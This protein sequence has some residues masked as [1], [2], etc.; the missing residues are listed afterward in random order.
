MKKLLA[1]LVGILPALS[2]SIVAMADQ[3]P[4]PQ[5]L[6]TEVENLGWQQ[7]PGIYKL[8]RSKSTLTLPEGMEIV[9]DADARRFLF[10]ANGAEFPETEAVVFSPV[11]GITTFAFSDIGYVTDDD[12]SEVDPDGLLKGISEGTEES[13]EARVRNGYP[14]IHVKGWATEPWYDAERRIA[15]WALELQTD[16]GQTIIN[17]IALKLGRYGFMEITL[18]VLPENVSGSSETLESILATHAYNDGQRYADFQDGDKVATLGLAALVAA[19]AA[20]KLG[21]GG[22]AALLAVL[23]VFLKKGWVVIA[24]ILGGSWAWLQR[25]KKQV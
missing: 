20:A 21:K 4:D 24:A 2:F 16:V 11:F 15:F 25:R 19:V 17:S 10:L 8:S 5:A 14:A 7:S 23:V 9:Q 12:W 22:L 1:I 13:N 6:E 18:I 3:I